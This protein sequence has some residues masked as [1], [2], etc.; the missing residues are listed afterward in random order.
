[1]KPIYECVEDGSLVEEP[2]ECGSGAKLLID[3]NRRVMLSKLVSG[4]LRH[5]PS[6]L[7]LSL[8]KEGWVDVETLVNAIRERWRNKEAY[9]WLRVEHVVAVALMDP[10][11]RFELRDGRIRARYGHSVKVDISYEEDTKSAKLYH[12]TSLQAYRAIMREG[13]KPG[14]RLWVHLSTT[15]EDAAETGRR[16]GRDV[17]VLTIDA[18][19]LRAR[20]LKIY[21]ASEKVRL[22]RYVPTECISHVSRHA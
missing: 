22:V 7:G 13:I 4:L 6:E 19:C 20:G 5:F 10:K 17:V 18:G 3:G 12:G 14:G 16:H 2:A 8:D 21:V 1:M 9:S 11:G 15:P